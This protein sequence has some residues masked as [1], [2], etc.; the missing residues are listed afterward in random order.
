MTDRLVD[1]SALVRLPA[2]AD[3]EEWSKQIEC[4]LVRI[5]SSTRLEVG[6]SARSATDLPASIQ[7]A[8]AELAG[9]T[10]L[11]VDKD[12]DL[13]AGVTGLDTERLRV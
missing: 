10:V 11:H 8:T 7:S 2:S 1:K 5:S 4:G 3:A 6:C 9:L 13:I 12:F